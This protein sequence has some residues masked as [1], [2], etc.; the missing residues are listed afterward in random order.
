MGARGAD[1]WALEER[2]SVNFEDEHYVRIYTKDTKTWLR[3]GW[4][5]QAVFMFVDRKLDKAGILDD[6][7]A[8]NA[9]EDI[10]L[11]TGLPLEVVE[12][13]L[14]RVLKSGTFEIVNGK[15]ICPN[16]IEANTAR[17]SAPL[18]AREYRERRRDGARGDASHVVTPRHADERESEKSDDAS[19]N[20]SDASQKVSPR[21]D[22]SH[23]I[24]PASPKSR[25]R[26][27]Q[28]QKEGGDTRPL[29]Q[30]NERDTSDLLVPCP[31]EP[32]DADTVQTVAAT[33]GA[34]P[35]AVR[36]CL[37]EFVTYWTIGGG[38]GRVHSRAKWASKAREDIRQAHKRGKMAEPAAQASEDENRRRAEERAAR[39]EEGRQSARAAF[40]TSKGAA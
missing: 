31:K 15:L 40:L 11:L 1:S 37:R 21:D 30:P 6:V 28:E 19:Q 32:L 24:T 29:G 13:G 33:L 34:S 16:Y 4:E 14:D 9:A 7:D 20:E 3:W 36:E 18:R 10:A 12:V 35:A 17:K 2:N 38:M 23:R 25:S 39:E 27:D 5:G 22:S 8:E 26:A